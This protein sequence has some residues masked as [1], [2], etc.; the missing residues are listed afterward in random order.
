MITLFNANFDEFDSAKNGGSLTT[1]IES[2]VA[3]SFI[4]AVRAYSAEF[5]GERWFKFFIKSDIDII[6]VGVD[7]AKPTLSESEEVYIGLSDAEYESDIDK[8]NF[9]IYGG[10]YV[11]S[12]DKA[13][14]K[15]TADRDVSE[16]IKEKDIVTFYDGDINRITAMKVDSV[17]GNEIVFK[18]W[19]DR[20]INTGYS[21]CSTIFFDSLDKDTLQPIW[22]KQVIPAYTKPMENPLDEFI[23]NIWYEIK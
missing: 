4:K 21:G 18:E 6:N 16:F 11:D 10:F 3:H 22:L 7:I 9:R 23:L 8:D 17:D 20:E 14:R 1:Q 12:V 2:G 5:G 13:N 15:I 19:S